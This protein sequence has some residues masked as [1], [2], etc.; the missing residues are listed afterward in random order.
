MERQSIH[1]PG[2][3]KWSDIQY[4]DLEARNG[5]TVNTRKNEIERQS[6][7]GPGGKKC[8]DSQYTDRDT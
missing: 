3:M 2:D 8:S 5:A 7:H 6:I 1:G 4:T